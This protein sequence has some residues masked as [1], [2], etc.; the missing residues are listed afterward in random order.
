M[1]ENTHHDTD[2]DWLAN[3][4]SGHSAINHPSELHGL[5]I[6]TLAAGARFTAE[7]WLTQVLEHMNVETLD[8]RKQVNL[9]ADLVAFYQQVDQGLE[10]DSDTLSC[11][12][13]DDDYPLEQRVEALT[14]WVRGFLEGL[15]LASKGALANVDSDLQELLQ[16]LIAITQLDPRVPSNEDGEKELFEVSEYVRVAVL[17][18]YAEFNQP[19]TGADHDVPHNPTLH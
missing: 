9:K 13:P 6:G 17:N 12:L 18:L 15:A 2:F 1:T 14:L 4:Y 19:S 7:E 11:L 8:D 3:I 5:L 10:K 16:D